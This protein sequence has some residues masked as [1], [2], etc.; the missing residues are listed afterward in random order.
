MNDYAGALEL[1]K[2]ALA[3]KERTFGPDDPDVAQS[4]NN[5]GS[6]LVTMKRFDEA[7]PIL[8]RAV[9]IAQRVG[10]RRDGTGLALA[11]LGE[12]WLRRG[13]P[14]KAKPY[15]EQSV[16]IFRPLD[17]F[18]LGP[19]L[20]LLSCV[21]RDLKENV[22]AEEMFES[23]LAWQAKNH[24]GAPEVAETLTEYARLKRATGRMS[25]AVA[26]E[27]RAAAI[28]QKSVPAGASP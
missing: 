24:A 13:E 19:T 9:D 15:L 14:R 6:I 23:T 18:F 2:R 11:S 4:L 22:A 10:H 12:L 16:E 7:Q 21:L 8:E 17:S 5:V 25:E 28:R 20:R 1:H 3:L 26:M 27:R